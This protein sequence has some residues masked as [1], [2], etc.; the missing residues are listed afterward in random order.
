MAPNATI[1]KVALS[2]ADLKRNFYQD[3][4]LTVARHPSETD[5]RMMIRVVAFA[6]NAHEHLKFGKGLS[7]SEEPDLWE[8]DLT[9]GI[10]HWIDL[11]Q[12]ADKRIRQACGK[13][14]RV[15]IYTYQ[16]GA[17]I[18]WFENVKNELKRFKHLRVVHLVV[19][20]ESLI[21]QILSRSMELNCTIE[22]EHIMLADATHSMT[23]DMTVAKEMESY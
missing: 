10:S 16:K 17:A 20:D 12:P 21:N 19:Q 11:G 3:Y 8:L 9:G 22:D 5:T 15:S 14:D 6:L 13:A 7:S 23:I 2:V 18:P 4:A 1:F